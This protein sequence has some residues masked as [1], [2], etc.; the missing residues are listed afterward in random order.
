MTE[1]V[2]GT[3]RGTGRKPGS[4]NKNG[5]RCEEIAEKMGIDPFAVL[6]LFASGN[7]KKLGYSEISAEVRSKC[8]AEAC[9][10]LH[11]Q[12]RSMDHAVRDP[13]EVIIKD[14]AGKGA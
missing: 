13:I 5:I 11:T 6:L 4:R 8:A 1:K 9:K 12:K 2:P 10:Y 3:G 14:Y 7:H